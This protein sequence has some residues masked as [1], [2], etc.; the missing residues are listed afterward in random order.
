MRSSSVDRHFYSVAPV[1]RYRHLKV[2]YLLSD[3][4]DEAP[5]IEKF[6]RAWAGDSPFLTFPIGDFFQAC[7]LDLEKL[8]IASDFW[9][10]IVE[11][12]Y[13]QVPIEL[14]YF[15]EILSWIKEHENSS[16][17][18]SYFLSTSNVPNKMFWLSF[19]RRFCFYLLMSRVMNEDEH[20]MTTNFISTLEQTL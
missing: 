14:N 8:V 13:E 20:S 5:K 4:D 6:P 11:Y 18:V 10:K 1:I 12:S 9:N 2:F 19:K 3:G 15:A 16:P 17:D 7:A